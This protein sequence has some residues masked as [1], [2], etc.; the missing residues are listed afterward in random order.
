MFGTV[1]TGKDWHS[2]VYPCAIGAS[3]H[4]IRW[5]IV[6][7]SPQS[8]TSTT[9][10][11]LF[12]EAIKMSYLSFWRISQK[13]VHVQQIHQLDRPMSLLQQASLLQ[14]SM[15]YV[16]FLAC[17]LEKLWQVVAVLLL[18][19]SLCSLYIVTWMSV[20]WI[21]T[22]DLWIWEWCLPAFVHQRYTGTTFT[23]QALPCYKATL[24]FQGLRH[25]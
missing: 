20:S 9:F 11:G 21:S 23:V 13:R 5:D 16:Y 6:S 8:H 7:L 12:N 14:Q 1:D 4:V 25:L 2:Q 3:T 10:G 24:Q 22:I 15:L 18:F 19:L 17:L